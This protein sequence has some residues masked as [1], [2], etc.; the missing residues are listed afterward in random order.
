MRV[1]PVDRDGRTNG[2]TRIMSRMFKTILAC[3]I[4]TGGAVAAA[5]WMV[6]RTFQINGVGW[7]ERQEFP[8]NSIWVFGIVGAVIGFAIGVVRHRRDVRYSEEAAE[9]SEENDFEFDAKPEEVEWPE[10][11][12]FA[13]MSSIDNRMTTKKDGVKVDVF[14]LTTVNQSSEST[15]YIRRTVVLLPAP[16]LI[17]FRLNA[18]SFGFRFLDWIGVKGV[19]FDP[20]ATKNEED[21]AAVEAFARNY[22]L[23]TGDTTELASGTPELFETQ[24]AAARQAFPLPVL[25]TLATR[26]GWSIESHGGQLAFWQGNAIHPPRKR[27]A[28][29]EGALQLRKALLH[30]AKPNE[31]L[32]AI[33]GTDRGLQSGKMQGA[34]LGGVIGAFAS[35]FFGFIAVM[36]LFMD[37]KPGPGDGFPFEMFIPLIL[38]LGTALGAFIGTR[39][40]RRGPLL[41]KPKDP[42]LEKRVGCA[43]L[44]GL[45]AG[46]LGGASLGAAAGIIL[47][48]GM[49]DHALRMGLFFGGA[50]VGFFTGPV[51]CGMLAHKILTRFQRKNDSEI[52][53]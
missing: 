42:K 46:F 36:V 9:I 7:L 4:G 49:D 38:V 14:D 1:V 43:V 32:P 21:R 37:R 11:P 10:I 19:T 28:M 16:G 48:L 18:K 53:P 12:L 35:F 50:G 17:E 27:L 6:N 13:N 15:Q 47:D 39:L 24:D 23:T 31:I 25:R 51:I 26:P 44:F 34:L 33:P 41:K 52:A 3:T 20:N 30:P 8:L 40:A 2:T 45:F 29:I 22:Q 5:W